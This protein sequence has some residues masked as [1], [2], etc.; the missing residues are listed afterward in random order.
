MKNQSFGRILLA[1][2][3]SGQA[4]AATN[5][6]ASLALACSA[7]VRVLHVWSL[8]V[9]HREGVWDVETHREAD[10]LID[11]AVKRLRALGVDASGQ[12]SRSDQ[13]HVA[14]AIAQAAKD[15]Q[16][17]LVVV[18]SRGL[19]DWQALLRHSVSH[20]LLSTLDSP[21]LVVRGAEAPL[22]HRA[23]RVLLA[24]AG[25]DDLEP[26]VQA[27]IAAASAPGSTVIVLHVAMAFVGAQG[28]SYV[29]TDEEIAATLDRATTMLKAAGVESETIVAEPTAVARAV[30]DT[31]AHERADIIVIGSSRMGDLPS[32]IFGSVTHQLLRAATKPVLV[33]ERTRR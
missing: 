26:A 23:Q 6:A 22:V 10:A 25:G 28:F 18:G 20:E 3:G 1:T 13:N 17:D 9:H 24:I 7:Q 4:D 19:S 12:I 33:A 2:D 31:A 11:E 5:A 15:F 29:E 21:V 32:L 30:A 14:A 27:A 16:A 8:E